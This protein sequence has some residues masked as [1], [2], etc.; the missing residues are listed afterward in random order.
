MPITV[1][2]E[3]MGI[4]EPVIGRVFARPVGSIHPTGYRNLRT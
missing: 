1:L 2:R 3:M 4:A